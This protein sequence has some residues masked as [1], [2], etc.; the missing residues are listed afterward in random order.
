[1]TRIE[2]LKTLH[3]KRFY[4]ET[5]QDMVIIHDFVISCDDGR[6]EI[7]NDEETLRILIKEEKESHGERSR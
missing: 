4:S 2:V 5:Y 3:G 1:M 6:T 7:I